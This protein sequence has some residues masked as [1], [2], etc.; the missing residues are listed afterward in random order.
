MQQAV[1]TMNALIVD[2]YGPPQNAR[3]GEIDVPK[4]KDG[5]LLV[6]MHAAGVNPFDYKV[7]TGAVKDWIRTTFPYVPGM[8]G[9]GEIVE[10]GAGVQNW[11]K[12]DAIVG[13]FAGGAFAQYA[14]ISAKEKRLARKPRALD[15]EHAAAIPEAGLTAK[16]MLRAAGSLANATV[17][18]IGATGGIGLFATQLAK[19]QGARVIATGRGDDIEYLRALGADD[20]IDYGAGDAIALTQQRYPSGVDVVLD[21][22]NSGEGILRD[23]QVLR[24]GGTLVSSLYGP[25]AAAFPKTLHVHY[26]QLA[27]QEGELQDLADRAAAGTLRVEIGRTYELSQA[28]QALADLLDRAKHTRGKL[29][30]RM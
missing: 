9:A 4:I 7:V 29:V 13:M 20:V 26:I 2:G 6:R 16:T 22:I 17:L 5:F 30:I 27:A 14:L 15:F 8:D 25:D 12:G 28:G 1:S 10:V 11:Q 3:A 18:I 21:V 23:A 24:A 19:A